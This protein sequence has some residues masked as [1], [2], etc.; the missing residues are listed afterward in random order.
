ME[1]N[2][3]ITSNPLEIS[4]HLKE[5]YDKI[6]NNESNYTSGSIEKFL[7]DRSVLKNLPKFSK[8]TAD[9]MEKQILGEEVDLAIGKLKK[10]TTPG[11]DGA[12]PELIIFIY[13]LV[14]SLVRDFVQEFLEEKAENRLNL[15]VK[16]IIFIKKVNNKTN[17]KQL[18]PIA[19]ATH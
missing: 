7:H 16:R 9:F 12:T 1:I 6:F 11:W 17:F 10:G 3:K 18:R 2:E 8:V 14:P 4:S 15:L 13:N 5:V 19:L